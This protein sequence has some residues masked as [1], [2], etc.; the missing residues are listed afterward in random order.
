MIDS[1][2]HGHGVQVLR[3]S[4]SQKP[5][6]GLPPGRRVGWIRT[7]VRSIVHIDE[8]GQAVPRRRPGE[9]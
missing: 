8:D 4:S 6:G 7:G 9:V 5:A 3:A 2:L 1:R